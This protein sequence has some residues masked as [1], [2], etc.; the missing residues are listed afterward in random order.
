VIKAPDASG[1]L[2]KS[3]RMSCLIRQRDPKKDRGV[4]APVV[5]D[6]VA[7]VHNSWRKGPQGVEMF[8][9]ISARLL[10]HVFDP[11]IEHDQNRRACEAAPVLCR[12]SADKTNPVC[13]L[14]RRGTLAQSVVIFS[15]H[16]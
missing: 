5:F 6:R 12:S 7:Q 4:S 14:T 1:G 8:D 15:R 10:G 13:R 9:E 11:A 2:G 16:A 3:R